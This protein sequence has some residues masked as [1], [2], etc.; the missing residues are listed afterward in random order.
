MQAG[1][2]YFISW[3]AHQATPGKVSK[4]SKHLCQAVQR[5]NQTVRTLKGMGMEKVTP[6]Q[7]KAKFRK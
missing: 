6:R 2:E 1:A 5:Q 7:T 3:T 4:S